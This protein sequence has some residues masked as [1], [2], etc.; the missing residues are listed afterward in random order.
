MA[1]GYDENL[2][3]YNATDALI[4]Y[5]VAE[6]LNTTIDQMRLREPADFQ[7]SLFNAVLESMIRGVRIDASRRGYFEETLMAELS[8]R[9][10]W[11]QSV[12]GHPL[13]PKSPKQMAKLF[14][15]DFNLRPIKTHEGNVT[16]N[17]AALRQLGAREPL[18]LPL[19]RKIQEIRSISVFLSTFVRMP[20]D[21]DQRMRCSFNICG[22]ST[23]RFS[24]SENAFGSGGNL[25]NIPEG[26]EDDDSDLDLP[27][28]RALFLADPGTFFWDLDLSASDLQIVVWEADE[29]ELKAMLKAGLD[30]YTEVAKEFYKDPTITKKD[31]RRQKFKSFS[32]GT[33]YLGSARGLA[34]R[35]GLTMHE[36][37]R[38]QQWYL[39]KFSNIKKWQ[40]RIK[41]EV[42]KRHRVSNIFGYNYQIFDRIDDGTYRAAVAWIGQSTTA[43][44]INRGYY[45]I[46]KNL[47]EVW[48]LMQVH[49]SLCG[50]APL[51]LKDWAI[52]RII[53]ECSITLP[54]R[55]DPLIIPVKVKTSDKSWGDCS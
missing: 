12:L 22:T 47:R 30:P 53:E 3:A 4:T 55:N 26:G 19:I 36:A 18:L 2:W 29:P 42:N 1:N 46:Y 50:T 51:P 28:I 6:S 45:N 15:T 9:E 32:H 39:G 10:S 37:E 31:P 44:L 34:Q 35:L 40:D 38:T 14:Y 48:V 16:L 49:D 21:H 24:S 20:L 52:Q 27:N 8:A 5:E 7:Q 23:Y 17:D 11:I 43:C 41:N 54:Y 33:N 25:Q 13:N